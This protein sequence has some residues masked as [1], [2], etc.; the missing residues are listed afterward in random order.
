MAPPGEAAGI[1]TANASEASV[2]RMEAAEVIGCS[3]LSTHHRLLDSR[4]HV[5]QYRGMHGER[6]L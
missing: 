5:P 4:I 6:H 3:S 1:D 2:I